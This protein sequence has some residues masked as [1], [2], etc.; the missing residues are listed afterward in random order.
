MEMPERVKLNTD[1]SLTVFLNNDEIILKKE[2]YVKSDKGKILLKHKTIRMLA[3]M[4]KVKI[5]PP[6]LISTHSSSV[7]VIARTAKLGD[8]ELTELGESNEKNLYDVIMQNNP[9]TTADNRAYERA[10]LKILKLYG[11]VYGASEIS[12]RDD[13][14][15][16]AASSSMP[17]KTNDSNDATEQEAPQEVVAMPSA[18]NDEK[19]FWWNDTGVGLYKESELNPEKVIVTQGPCAGKNW[20]VKLL[21]E[22][23]YS[24]CLY[25]AERKSLESA[26]DDFKR[27]VYACRRAI[28]EYGMKDKG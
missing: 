3:E 14:E 11:E 10:V 19:P 28:R 16:P 5:G 21:Y 17:D 7:Y 24:S 20:T 2:D 15:S 23:Q 27:Q 6:L 22:Y 25:F 18:K 1:K 26:N 8:E 4:A 9:A 13:D 12:F